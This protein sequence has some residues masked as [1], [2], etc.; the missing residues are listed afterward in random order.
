MSY[1]RSSIDNFVCA[2]FTAA[3]F[4]LCPVHGK[5]SSTLGLV[6]TSYAAAS[7]DLCPMLF[8]QPFFESLICASIRRAFISVLLFGLPILQ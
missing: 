1:S 4:D 7:F 8:A 5:N 2:S 3:L 6:Y